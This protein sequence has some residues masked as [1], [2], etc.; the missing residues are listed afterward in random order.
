MSGVTI[1]IDKC[2]DACHD[3]RHGRIR[4][5]GRK[6]IRV[7]EET[8]GKH[9]D[10][11]IFGGAPGDPGLIGPGSMS[12]EIHSDIGA[13]AAAGLAAIVMEI[14]HPSVMAGVYTQSSYR[15][16]TFRRAQAT[17]GYVVVT[18][19][20]NTAAATRTINRVRQM[21]ERVNGITPDGRPYRAMDPVLIGWVH[22]CIPWAIMEAFDRYRRPMTVAEKNRYLAEQAVIGRLGGAD[23]IPVT[24]DQLR[25]YVEAM[26]PQLA[27]NEQTVEF[28]DFLIG[29]VEGAGKVN[30]FEQV[31]RRL[32]LHGS[33]SLMP[34]WAQRLTALQHSDLAQRLYFDPTT[35]LNIQLINWAFGVP[36]YRAL[37]DAR[38][39]AVAAAEPVPPE[40]RQHSASAPVHAR[41]PHP[42]ASEHA[43]H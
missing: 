34:E 1:Y 35:R 28:I 30:G 27:V 11:A 43:I 37:A 17:F 39:A 4:L 7:F 10:P 15:T 26:R 2:H 23:D 3:G 24:V 12:W 22:T 42:A 6:I 32:S 31:M 33:M 16:Q 5:D 29:S 25:D 19:F 40:P 20:G 21:H 9:D 13:I 38:V 18:T 41:A 14:L 8:V 36:A